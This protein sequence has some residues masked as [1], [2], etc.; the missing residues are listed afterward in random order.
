M[1]RLSPHDGSN[2]VLGTKFKP[3][4][5]WQINLVSHMITHRERPLVRLK[6]ALFQGVLEGRHEASKGVVERALLRLL[7]ARAVLPALWLILVVDA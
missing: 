5:M 1:Q 2:V 7:A 4:C 3:A 6:D